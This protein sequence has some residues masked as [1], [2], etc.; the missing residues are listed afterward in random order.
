WRHAAPA[1]G[2]GRPLPIIENFVKSSIYALR[3]S[4]AQMHGPPARRG[5]GA[6]HRAPGPLPT[7]IGKHRMKAAEIR[8]TFLKFFESKGHTIVPSS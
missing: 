4:R 5:Q 3:G 6:P 8:Q 2:G 7:P 1:R